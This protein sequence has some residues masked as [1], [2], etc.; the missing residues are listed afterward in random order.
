MARAC[1][2]ERKTSSIIPFEA[3]LKEIYEQPTVTKKDRLVPIAN[4]FENMPGCRR[5]IG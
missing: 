4:N 2:A 1:R 5:E 3:N